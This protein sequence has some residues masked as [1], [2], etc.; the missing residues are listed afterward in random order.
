[1]GNI[2]NSKLDRFATKTLL[3]ER[4][5]CRSAKVKKVKRRG[6]KAEHVQH[7]TIGWDSPGPGTRSAQKIIYTIQKIWTAGGRVGRGEGGGVF[8]HS[9]GGPLSKLKLK[10][11]SKSSI[12]SKMELYQFSEQLL[13]CL[14]HSL[15]I[16]FYKI[17]RNLY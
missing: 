8:V 4:T 14:E 7:R 5:K 12:R 9:L 13:G 1:M 11:K 2:F 10:S 6:A 17:Y 15:L 3:K 16:Y